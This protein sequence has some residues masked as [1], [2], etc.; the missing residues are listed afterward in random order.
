MGFSA[1]TQP[2]LST[3]QSITKSHASIARTACLSLLL[4]L[5]L[6]ITVKGQFTYTTNNGTITITGYTGPAGSVII[7]GTIDLLPVTGVGTRAFQWSSLLKEVTIPNSVSN[8]AESAF[9]ECTGL[10]SLSIGNGVKS[11]G[12]AAFEDCRSLA[13]LT[14]PSSVNSIGDQAMAG[15]TNLTGVYFQGNGPSLGTDLFANAN[16]ATVYYL[17]GTIGWGRTFAGR[18]TELWRPQIQLGNSGYGVRTDQSGFN[19]NW[20]NGT[21]VVV[22]AATNLAYPTWSPLQTITLT[23]GSSYFS[24]PLW[25]TYPSRFYRLRS[26]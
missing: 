5:A 20:A 14:I 17:P 15:C 18:P 11:I 21:T 26:P 3:T 4:V 7:P 19:I 25:T 1:S 10:T 8:I 12:G 22:E 23:N 6:P 2:T 13:K 24:D 16:H 9:F